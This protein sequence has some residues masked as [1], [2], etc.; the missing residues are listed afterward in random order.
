MVYVHEA[1]ARRSDP[2]TAVAVAEQPSDF[3]LPDSGWE[4][5]QLLRFPIDQSSDRAP[6]GD[7]E[8]A[9]IPFSQTLDADRLAGQRIEFWRTGL[10]SPQAVRHSHPEIT[11][12]VLL[13]AGNVGAK[14]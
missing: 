13:Q 4:H 1:P 14:M 11:L 2:Q 9:V 10:P 6:I 7:E 3:E 12:A 5:I 8:C